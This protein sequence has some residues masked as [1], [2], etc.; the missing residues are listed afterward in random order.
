[1]SAKTFVLVHGIWHGGWCWSRVAEILRDR[2]H[3]VSAPT[4]TG[5]GERAHLL[6]D[7]ITLQTFVDDIVNHL[8]FE[9]LKDVILVGHSFGGASVT[10]VA[11]RARDRIARLIFLDAIMLRSG[12]TWLSLL[13]EGTAAE[14][15]ALAK[16]T[17][18]GLSLPVAA[19]GSFGMTDPEHIAFLESRL[20]PHPFKTIT[21]SVSLAA[22]VGNGLPAVY[23]RCTDP[24]YPPAVVAYQRAL[25]LGWPVAE[26]L[27][28]HDAMVTAPEALAKLLEQIAG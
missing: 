4:Q 25:E 19:P 1:M 9:D 10:G 2:G 20:T 16:R 8:I 27:T 7:N 14:R 22:P 3:S 5:L 13:P 24:V 23:I 15:T 28:G 26:L 18:G 6:C 17:S 12:E 11:D 21:T